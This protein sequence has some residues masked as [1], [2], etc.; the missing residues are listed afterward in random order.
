LGSFNHP[1]LHHKARRPIF[2]AIFPRW[3]PAALIIKVDAELSLG[4]GFTT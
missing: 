1:K 3:F 2:R 4:A